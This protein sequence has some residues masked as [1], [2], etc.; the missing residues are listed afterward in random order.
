MVALVW[1][2]LF[3]LY[4]DFWDPKI[5]EGIGNS[6]GSFVKIFDSTRQGRYTSYAHIYVYMNITESLSKFIELEYWNEEWKQPLDYDHIPFCYRTC[7]EYNHLYKECHLNQS[8]PM[9]YHIDK[10]ATKSQDDSDGF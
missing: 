7:H 4:V 3:I 1:V 2:R 9:V 5:L 10:F 8:K 6:I